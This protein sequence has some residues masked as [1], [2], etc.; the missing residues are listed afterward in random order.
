MTDQDILEPYLG[1]L[2][3]E[4]W[5]Y[6][7]VVGSTNDWALTWARSGAPDWSLVLAD[8][9]TAGRGRMGREWV[10]E[11]GEALAMSL[12]LRPSGQE[13]AYFQRFTALAGLGL[14]HA[15]V[16]LGLQG[17]IKWP[18]DILLGGKKVAGVLVEADWKGPIVEALV[19]GMGVNI[20]PAALP[21]SV[22]LRYP[23]T[24]IAGEAGI[25]LDRWAILA[26]ILTAMKHMRSFMTQD[27]FVSEWNAKL[28]FKGEFVMFRLPGEG[29]LTVKILGVTQKGALSIERSDGRRINVISGEI[30]AEEDASH[31]S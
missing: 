13:T 5:Q 22:E 30:L 4:A 25:Q 12:I 15:L 3:L 18:N 1:G 2:G 26:D 8:T 16:N 19:V 23:A 11:P 21:N 7:P 24:S 10:T 14:I 20:G 6:Y 29:L 9:Q 28:A 17:R 27:A 31:L